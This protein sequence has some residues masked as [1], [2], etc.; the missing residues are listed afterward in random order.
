M[1]KC[2]YC[3]DEIPEGMMV[4]PTC[5]NKLTSPVR[6]KEGYVMKML[7]SVRL[8]MKNFPNSFINSNNELIFIPKFNVSTSLKDVETDEDFKVKLCE[9]LSR[10]CCCALRYSQQ[11]RLERYWQ[12]NTDA[13]NQICGTNFT[14]EQMDYIYTYLG[15]GIKHELTRQFVRSEFDLS[16]IER[17]ISKRD[18]LQC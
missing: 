10:D 11:K 2:L 14:V 15:N 9:W 3:Y 18:E 1:P 4:C 6:M 8:A 17:Y 16:I 12:D 13:F 5:E 7:E